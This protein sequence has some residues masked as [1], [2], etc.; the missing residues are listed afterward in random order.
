MTGRSRGEPDLIWFRRP[1]ARRGPEPTL[2][3]DQIT[4][5]AVE[6]AD[7]G[8]L[9]SVSMRKIAASLGVGT[10]SLYWHVLS[11]DDLYELM[12][13]EVIGEIRLPRSSGD[14]L[15]DLRKVAVS[16]YETYHRHQWI[17]QLGIQPGL[18]PKTRRFGDVAL[19]LLEPLGLDLPTRIGVLA[20][21]NNYIF[22]FIHREV[23]WE[24]LR[25]RS[26][27]DED[28]WPAQLRGYLDSASEEGDGLA[29]QMEAR[30]GLVGR[31]SFAFG[32]DCVLDG[33][34]VRFNSDHLA[35]HSADRQR[36]RA[37]SRRAPS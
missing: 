16:S 28:E 15:R 25:Q 31:E 12:V 17:V 29:A 35:D 4:K 10:T 14:W 26:G 13:D 27:L 19:R 1:R 18:G 21:L 20:T 24:Q 7:V 9:E 32:L 3:R 34:A 33:I 2:S 23:A 30:F 6:L 37:R 11:K 36:T 5:L 22:G 8:G